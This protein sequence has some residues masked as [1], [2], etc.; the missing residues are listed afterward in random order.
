MRKL[1]LMT[2]VAIIL[3]LDAF[4]E[5]ITCT[6]TPNCRNLG[7]TE[8]SCPNDNGVRCPWGNYW[9]CPPETTESKTCKNTCAVGNI[10]YSDM[11]C[12]VS[13]DI[14][15]TPIGVVVYTDGQGRGQA[16]AL[17]YFYGKWSIGSNGIGVEDLQDLSGNAVTADFNSTR[18][19]KTIIGTGSNEEFP[20]AWIAYEY[21]TPGTE[22]G[23]WSLPAAGVV[24]TTFNNLDTINIGIINANGTILDT[25]NEIWSSTEW[26]FRYAYY[27]KFSGEENIVYMTHAEKDENMMVRPVFE[28]IETSSGICPYAY[29]YSCNGNNISEGKGKTCGGKYKSCTC[30]EGYVWG[31]GNCVARAEWGQCNGYAAGC[32]VG[33]ILYSD[34]TCNK[35]IISEKTAIAVVAYVDN[36]DCG[37]ALALN[38]LGQ[39]QW[40]SN[41]ES[42]AGTQ[43]DYIYRDSLEKITTS[44]K[45]TKIV[46]QTGDKKTFPA[47]WAAYE[48]STEGTKAGDWCLPAPGIFDP[49][50]SNQNIVD[51]ALKSVGGT[52]MGT[53]SVW[54]PFQES[55]Y[56]TH[57][58]IWYTGYGSTSYSSSTSN[59]EV[60]PVI[61]F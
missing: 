56:S 10:L 44:C 5:N 51:A 39:Y 52:A 43:F 18:N 26:S 50:R 60:R 36:N 38:S 21:S 19:T 40:A 11:T 17:E 23:E 25:N 30:D 22:A 20:A 47:A 53:T 13:L 24:L 41:G 54:S 12:S 45:T 46:I 37:Q 35:N 15:K 34:G 14:S 9:F 57:G 7:Y 3:P 16:M 6:A 28:F 2:G 33:D 8:V 1:I 29:Q 59:Y 49:Y 55:H 32:S 58:Y 31:K 48:Y 42:R 61:E 4:A 27:S